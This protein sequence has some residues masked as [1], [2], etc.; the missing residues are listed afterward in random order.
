M[1]SEHLTHEEAQSYVENT[2]GP[3]QEHAAA[4]LEVCGSCRALVKQYELLFQGLKDETG[5]ELPAGFAGSVA[6]KLAPQHT[7]SR[8]GGLIWSLA[9]SAATAFLVF[10]FLDMSWLRE[11]VSSILLGAG[12]TANGV[13]SAFQ[14]VDARLPI[15]SGLLIA[16]LLI[17]LS[18]AALDRIILGIRRSK[19][20]FLAL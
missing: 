13:A 18:V 20:M 5:F 9:G 19:A 8:Y 2:L 11:L 6:A 12:D 10:Y 16:P 4:H 14:T 3:R 7:L 17:L 1:K 15:R